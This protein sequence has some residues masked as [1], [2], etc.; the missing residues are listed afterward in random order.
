MD[1]QLSW[2]LTE[3]SVNGLLYIN[4]TI[5]ILKNITLNIDHQVNSLS[6]DVLYFSNSTIEAS[7]NSL[8]STKLQIIILSKENQKQIDLHFTSPFHNYENIV[9][10][11]TKK[12]KE[13]KL[14]K[15]WA[16]DKSITLD[17]FY[18]L[19]YRA[20]IK[21]TSPFD[22]YN[23]ASF[24]YIIDSSTPI[25]LIFIKGVLNKNYVTCKLKGF[26]TREVSKRGQ[27]LSQIISGE[28]ET[29]GN[30]FIPSFV[31]N[32]TNK[33]DRNNISTHLV[34]IND[35]SV[36]LDLNLTYEYE[37]TKLLKGITLDVITQSHKINGKLTKTNIEKLNKYNFEGVWNE[38]N[39]TMSLFSN[40]N[41][42]KIFITFDASSSFWRDDLKIEFFNEYAGQHS[43]LEIK[44]P[45]SRLASDNSLLPSFVIIDYSKFGMNVINAEVILISPP[46]IDK[47]EAKY[48][49]SM[50]TE[51]SHTQQF[52]I[53]YNKNKYIIADFIAVMEKEEKYI[54]LSLM[55]PLYK[56]IGL[57]ANY[58]TKENENINQ[59]LLK[60]ELDDKI[61]AVTAET[62]IIDMSAKVLLSIETSDGGEIINTS[63][64]YDIRNQEWLTEVFISYF[65]SITNCKIFVNWVKEGKTSTKLPVEDWEK[66]MIIL[67]EPK[68]VQFIF[69]Q[70]QNS[71][72]MEFIDERSIGNFNG[73]MALNTKFNNVTNQYLSILHCVHLPSD[74]SL[75]VIHKHNDGTVFNFN[76][77]TKYDSTSFSVLTDANIPFKNWENL[78]CKFRF[79]QTNNTQQFNGVFERNEFKYELKGKMNISSKILATEMEFKAPDTNLTFYSKY[80]GSENHT[81]YVYAAYNTDIIQG[82]STL[83]IYENHERFKQGWELESDFS[84]NGKHYKFNSGSDLHVID[85]LDDVVALLKENLD[86]H[87]IL[88]T[89]PCEYQKNMY[90]ELQYD[91]VSHFINYQLHTNNFEINDHNL[92]ISLPYF[93][94]FNFNLNFTRNNLTILSKTTNHNLLFVGKIDN[95]KS[96]VIVISPIVNITGEINGTELHLSAFTTVHMCNLIVKNN[97][98]LLIDFNSN[99]ENWENLNVI[100]DFTYTN[101]I[102]SVV[103]NEADFKLSLTICTGLR[104][105]DGNI[106][107][108]RSGFLLN[109]Q[110]SYDFR[111]YYESQITYNLNGKSKKFSVKFIFDANQTKINF[112]T[113]IEGYEDLKL[114][115]TYDDMNTIFVLEQNTMKTLSA[116]V[117]KQNDDTVLTITSFIGSSEYINISLNHQGVLNTK[118]KDKIISIK[119]FKKQM[120][121]LDS[122]FAIFLDASKKIGIQSHLYS[123][124]LKPI[125]NH[126]RF[127]ACLE[128]GKSKIATLYI[129]VNQ[130]L[131]DII[132]YIEGSTNN[133]KM[134][135]STPLGF[136]RYQLISIEINYNLIS[137]KNSLFLQVESKNHLPYTISANVFRNDVLSEMNIEFNTE[138]PVDINNCRFHV[139]YNNSDSMS[140]NTL[141]DVNLNNYLDIS[142]ITD[143]PLKTYF[144]AK[145]KQPNVPLL[146]FNINYNM[147]V[148]KKNIELYITYNTAVYEFNGS[149]ELLST[150]LDAKVYFNTN[151]IQHVFSNYSGSSYNIKSEVQYDFKESSKFVML[152]YNA[153]NDTEYNL[154][155]TSLNSK[156]LEFVVKLEQNSGIPFLDY[157]NLK[158]NLLDEAMFNV[159]TKYQEHSV[160]INCALDS[161]NG[162]MSFSHLNE[163][164]LDNLE[165]AYDYNHGLNMSLFGIFKSTKSFEILIFKNHTDK[166]IKLIIYKLWMP[167]LFKFH[168][169]NSLHH[170]QNLKWVLSLLNGNYSSS[171]DISN[172]GDFYDKY[173]SKQFQFNS[174]LT[175]Q[176]INYN[177]ECSFSKNSK[178]VSKVIENFTNLLFSIEGQIDCSEHSKRFC[179]ERDNY[180]KII[181]LTEDPIL[182]NYYQKL[183]EHKKSLVLLYNV[184]G[185]E[186]S[187]SVEM[188]IKITDHSEIEWKNTLLSEIYLQ[189]DLFNHPSNGIQ[190][191][192]TLYLNEMKQFEFE[193]KLNY[194]SITILF[195]YEPWKFE[196]NNKTLKLLM[197]KEHIYVEYSQLHVNNYSFTFNSTFNVLNYFNLNYIQNNN[198]A[199]FVHF[200][201]ISDEHNIE[202]KAEGYYEATNNNFN[203]SFV[204]IK[205]AFRINFNKIVEID[206]LVSQFQIEQNGIAKGNG[207]LKYFQNEFKCDTEFMINYDNYSLH[208]DLKSSPNSVFNNISVLLLTPSAEYVSL[209]EFSCIKMDCLLHQVNYV[210]YEKPIKEIKSAEITW[211]F[212]QYS[213]HHET[214]FKTKAG[215]KTFSTICEMYKTTIVMKSSWFNLEETGLI[216]G[217]D[218]DQNSVIVKLFSELSEINLVHDLIYEKGSIFYSVEVKIPD[219]DIFGWKHLSGLTNLEGFYDK[220]TNE[221]KFEFDSPLI[222]YAD[223]LFY[224][225]Q[226]KDSSTIYDLLLQQKHS[227][228]IKLTVNTSTE[229]N[230]NVSGHFL[231]HTT[232]NFVLHTGNNNIF[233]AVELVLFSEKFINM[234]L[235]LDQQVN[236]WDVLLIVDQFVKLSN[237][238]TRIQH[239]L[240]MFGLNIKHELIDVHWKINNNEEGIKS[241]LLIDSNIVN[242]FNLETLS[243]I[244]FNKTTNCHTNI[245]LSFANKFYIVNSSV[246]AT[247]NSVDMLVDYSSFKGGK[248]HRNTF[249]LGGLLTKEDKIQTVYIYVNNNN[250]TGRLSNTKSLLDILIEYSMPDVNINGRFNFKS[251]ISP[252]F[253]VIISYD[254]L[255]KTCLL[256]FKLDNKSNSLQ[257]NAE[258]KIY[259]VTHLVEFNVFWKRTNVSIELNYIDDKLQI[260]KSSLENTI[261][262]EYQLFRLIGSVQ[263]PKWNQ[264]DLETIYNVKNKI[265]KITSNEFE[266]HLQLDI[267]NCNLFFK[268]GQVEYKIEYVIKKLEYLVNISLP[269]AS[270]VVHCEL[271]DGMLAI[272]SHSNYRGII[273]EARGTIIYNKDYKR[274]LIELKNGENV[275]VF[276]ESLLNI[277][278]ELIELTGVCNVVQSINELHFTHNL[279]FPRDTHLSISS[280]LLSNGIIEAGIT[281]KDA[282][283]LILLRLGQTRLKVGASFDPEDGIKINIQAPFFSKMDTAT[284]NGIF[285][286]EIDE[287][288]NELNRYKISAS[289][290][291]TS[292]NVLLSQASIKFEFQDLSHVEVLVVMKTKTKQIDDVELFIHIPLRLN[293]NMI[294][295]VSLKLSNIQPVLLYFISNK[296]KCNSTLK[297]FGETFVSSTIENTMDSFTWDLNILKHYVFLSLIKLKIDQILSVSYNNKNL[298]NLTSGCYNENNWTKF[299]WELETQIKGHEK[300][301][302]KYEKKI[303]EHK[304]M[305][306]FLSIPKIG[307]DLGFDLEYLFDNITHNIITAKFHLPFIVFGKQSYGFSFSNN[308]NADMKTFEVDYYVHIGKFLGSFSSFVHA[309]NNS[310]QLRG[311]GQLNNEIMFIKLSTDFDSS[312]VQ[313]YIDV[314]TPFSIVKDSKLQVTLNKIVVGSKAHLSYNSRTIA[315]LKINEKENKMKFFEL[316]SIWKSAS[317]GYLY[318]VGTLLNTLCLNLNNTDTSQLCIEFILKSENKLNHYLNSKFTLGSNIVEIECGCT[319]VVSDIEYFSY[320][321][322]G[323]NRTVGFKFLR[324]DSG[325]NVDEYLKYN[326]LQIVLPE[327]TIEGST[328]ILKTSELQKGNIEFK[329]DLHN[330]PGKKI[331]VG[332][333]IDDD[334]LVNT[335]TVQHFA[336]QH[337]FVISYILN[338]N[339]LKLIVQYSPKETELF[340]IGASYWTFS[341][342]NNGITG[343]K[344]SIEHK[345]SNIFIQLLANSTI[346]PLKIEGHVAISYINSTHNT[347]KYIELVGGYNFE[348]KMLSVDLDSNGNSFVASG[349]FWTKENHFNGITVE[350]RLNQK[351]PI[352]IEVGVNTKTLELE[353]E[354]NHGLSQTY[355]LYCGMPSNKEITGKISH[356]LNGYKNTDALLMLKL[357]TTKLLWG[358]FEFN[359]GVFADLHNTLLVEYSDVELIF[360]ELL[361]VVV[362]FYQEELTVSINTVGKSLFEKVNLVLSSTFTEFDLVFNYFIHFVER[363]NKMYG[364]NQFYMQD[365]H[366]AWT[367][368]L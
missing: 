284:I 231:K 318:D 29:E 245:T 132:G 54:S 67:F 118:N 292:D 322:W 277:Q 56:D 191:I 95:K 234:S 361:K 307:T 250:F 344:F 156:H 51:T 306:I 133:G 268:T 244:N 58:T 297:I 177:L 258:I 36:V 40:C 266:F 114:T 274:F 326:L 172:T 144:S 338:D 96:S 214:Q 28:I 52:D 69:S 77:K 78:K 364:Q 26:Q 354:F 45:P 14:L 122:S 11:I 305:M 235:N 173:H 171:G 249:K 155:V 151:E 190:T 347:I 90:F 140:V 290:A 128:N 91:D 355:L 24:D 334:N 101:L 159:R 280:P 296:H 313:L 350:T 160:L 162:T 302:I 216:I 22:G 312:K 341:N 123:K 300:Y 47:F 325:D 196:L 310:L 158:Y 208:L 228:V 183:T 83:N 222:N 282:S 272:S 365:I 248:I 186:S 111:K 18:E 50:L 357:N 148:L 20:R 254:L 193:K 330:N 327:R 97:N 19:P 116:S 253:E 200:Y 317:F 98:N 149:L 161:V 163:N 353:V 332:Y 8:E 84:W 143:S 166:E 9:L 124:V 39:I 170:V 303:S 167:N 62:F 209:T 104:C 270:G 41:L 257:S 73:S 260:Y 289:V 218:L 15:S 319:Y 33:V 210:L 72:E 10:N 6:L 188:P 5:D 136:T 213:K 106:T 119:I 342:M 182:I 217:K 130:P 43:R 309:D 102:I 57:S 362:E 346:T 331:G 271:D 320:L 117:K 131:I 359:K 337:D 65:G 16:K 184:E 215:L 265:L 283:M 103:Q 281:S 194:T 157:F 13:F 261:D 142:I 243:L 340:I 150:C 360:S 339:K 30:Y 207:T 75:S 221:L 192:C 4:G 86:L 315:E 197:G 129:L 99:I 109:T 343:A 174:N 61:Y 87:K 333:V 240:D 321:S 237:L 285:L 264:I 295:H 154:N 176:N 165:V 25:N 100:V 314:G 179:E 7:Y 189:F 145:L 60:A 64:I 358:R 79:G 236:I 126:I 367:S 175:L 232:I 2:Q 127:V 35:K 81:L 68:K 135:L 269:F 85:N 141:V 105:A 226:N 108:T 205:R 113:P 66:V 203:A 227:D 308:I 239:K 251:K 349:S 31:T 70:N 204:D 323:N 185:S 32:F 198:N 107:F 301:G 164:L 27:M 206:S 299:T 275:L 293:M 169:Q 71:I 336:L 180:M 153:N 17:Y 137:H 94:E 139:L 76:T 335:L 74:Y 294:T 304:K 152:Y 1:T 288:T 125:F 110:A 42:P 37:N 241:L 267:N 82:L 247:V 273:F 298:F 202:W 195:Q 278:N 59:L 49:Y 146:Q 181:G 201:T 12:D 223:V 233:S 3:T 366:H 187:I 23:L 229:H 328:M 55:T 138:N 212:N 120:K 276:T 115:G 329:W 48:K 368:A 351:E 230:I 246:S 199:I 88:Q 220:T 168:I 134:L 63:L 93:A 225:S 287:Y 80:I 263:S 352:K 147:L 279:S 291:F 259:N 345:A 219:T 262:E 348:K 211:K 38:D 92:S 363:L 112:I 53:E 256:S 356:T 46:L 255:G 238:T 44:L 34:M 311:K 252:I 286:K 178:F 121:I 89:I 21:F 316:K 224:I 324:E 242:N